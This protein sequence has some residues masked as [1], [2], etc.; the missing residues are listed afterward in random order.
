MRSSE[1]L[2][3][4][5]DGR[6]PG[7]GYAHSGGLEAAVGSGLVHDAASLDAF[8]TGRLHTVGPLDA[9]TAA[10]ACAGVDPAE[11]GALYDA[12]TPSPAQRRASSMLGRGLLRSSARVWPGMPAA[13]DQHQAVACGLVAR[14]AGLDPLDAARLVLHALVMGS[15]SAAPKLLAIDTSEA[16]RIAVRLAVDVDELA[17]AALG[18]TPP[19][20]RSGVMAE[21][22]AEEHAA[23]STRLFAS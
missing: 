18:D 7:G 5:G 17:S 23:W 1:L 14:H 2:L 6:W 9:W 12:R 20:A 4:L 3:L 15:I 21:L 11:L 13:S 22:L 10:R 16:L 8:V 19:P